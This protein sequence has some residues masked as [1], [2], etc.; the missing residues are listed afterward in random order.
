MLDPARLTWLVVAALAGCG[1]I[2]FDPLADSRSSD[3][4]DCGHTFCDHFD[5]RSGP[6]EAGWDG[7]T[8][9]TGGTIALATDQSVSAPQSLLI[10]IPTDGTTLTGG[11]FLSKQLPLAT[12]KTFVHVQLSYATAATMNTEVDLMHLMWDTLPTGCTSFGFFFVRDGTKPFNLQEEYGDAGTGGL[13]AGGNVQ[14]YSLNLDNTPFH[15]VQLEVT[16]GVQG[17]AHL[18]LTVDGA[19]VVDKPATHAIAPSTLTLELG[20]GVSRNG[21]APWTIRYDDVLVDI[22]R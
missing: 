14:N 17:T 1:R 3:A 2:D 19:T 9:V 16:V 20:G 12:T 18:K 7:Y 13:C 10:T 6:P 22:D 15:D 11:R 8:N 21:L 4:F 5:D